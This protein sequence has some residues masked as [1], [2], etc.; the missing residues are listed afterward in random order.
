MVFTVR[1]IN[2]LHQ[3]LFGRKRTKAAWAIGGWES[4]S[5]EG[6]SRILFVCRSA[7]S[8]SALANKTFDRFPSHV[9]SAQTRFEA[10]IRLTIFPY[11]AVSHK[12]SEKD[13]IWV[14]LIQ[15]DKLFWLQYLTPVFFCF[16]HFQQLIKHSRCRLY[17]DSLTDLCEGLNLCCL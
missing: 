5:S 6:W 15:G 2:L 4:F 10:G 8:V 7:L 14:S 17:K 12:C 16:V 1:K 13:S 3:I 9:H 11:R